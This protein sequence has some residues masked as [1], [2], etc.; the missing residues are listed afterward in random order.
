[1]D[2][3]PSKPGID[4]RPPTFELELESLINRYSKENDSNTPDFILAHYLLGCLKVWNDCVTDREKW[5][6][7]TGTSPATIEQQEQLNKNPGW[8]QGHD[9]A[10]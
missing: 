6:G 2:Y 3:D 8:S 1:M 10:T 5:Y 4:R 7:R 9:E